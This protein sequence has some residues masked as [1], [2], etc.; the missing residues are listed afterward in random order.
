MTFTEAALEVLERDGRPMHARDIAERAVAWGL[1]S[2]VGKTPVQTMSAR[3]STVV[4]KGPDKS[5]FVRVRPGV[6]ALAKWKGEPPGPKGPPPAP[7]QST[8]APKPAPRPAPKPVPKP[9]P[10]PA[11]AAEPAEQGEPAPK[12]RRRRRRKKRSDSGEGASASPPAQKPATQKPAEPK[13]TVKPASRPSDAPQLNRRASSAEPIDIAERAVEVLRNHNA[14]LAPEA[15]T[16]AIGWKGD[17]SIL[18]LDALLTAEGLDRELRGLRPRFVRHRSGWALAEREVSSEIVELERQVS[19]AADRLSQLAE[20][21]IQRR[22]RS[23][24]LKA[25]VRVVIMYL[26][27]QGFDSMNPVERG[28]GDEFHLSVLDRRGGGQFRTA[29]VIR[30]DPTNKPV[31]DRA[32]SDLR[33]ALHHY[34]SMSAL[35]V[36]TGMFDEQARTEAV[37][38]N[39]PPVALVDGES[40]ARELARVSIGVR[41]RKVGLPAF[42]D[43]FFSALGA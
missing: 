19:E 20:R 11:V 8:P 14:P 31:T 9:V 18:M 7:R 25:L 40:L 24:P 15:L 5:P 6:F 41:A 3:I 16:K 34:R 42:D 37:V 17:R 13:P 4:A 10:K 38:S 26:R 2:H 22:L 27:R 32:V 12:K 23:L 35:I 28:S 29:V 33:G 30:R 43:A 36:T 39:L 1:L 21:Q